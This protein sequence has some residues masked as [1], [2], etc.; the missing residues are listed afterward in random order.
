MRIGVDTSGSGLRAGAFEVDITA[1][2]K[3]K[4]MKLGN[5]FEC[6]PSRNADCSW[7]GGVGP[8]QWEL[9][10]RND[11]V[12]AVGGRANWMQIERL[13]NHRT[14]AWMRNKL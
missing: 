3:I 4:A 14:E 10:N 5:P 8:I 13:A 7:V 1:K 2:G 9:K 12:N 6:L 11:Q